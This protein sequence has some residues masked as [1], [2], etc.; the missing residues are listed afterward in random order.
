MVSAAVMSEGPGNA[1]AYGQDFEEFGKY[2]DWICPMIYKGN[3]KTDTAWIGKSTAYINNK[4][5]GNVITGLQTYE[6]MMI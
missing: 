6:V 5:S 3:Y 4:A 1:D 2:L